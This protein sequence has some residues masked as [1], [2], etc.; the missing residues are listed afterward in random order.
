[1]PSRPAKTTVASESVHGVTAPV[2]RRTAALLGLAL[3]AVIAVRFAEPLQDGDLFS[4]MAYARQMLARGTL[5]LDHAAFSWTPAV[6]DMIYCAWASEL[7]FY[8]LWEHLG[9]TSLFAFRY[10]VVLLVAGLAFIH[11][12]RLG[13]GRSLLTHLIVLILIL[14][15]YTGTFVKP[16]LFSLLGINVLAHVVF[17]AKHRRD[18]PAGAARL[19][20]LVPLVVLV[21]V[22]CHGGFILA[23]PFLLMVAIGEGLNRLWSPGL[24]FSRRTY[25]HLLA[26]WALAGV[27]IVVTPYG[28]AYPRNSLATTSWGSGRAPTWRGTRRIVRSSRPSAVDSS[29]RSFS[30]SWRRCWARS[31][32]CGCVTRRAARAS[33]G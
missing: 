6:S 30:S 14:A 29:S 9:I 32:C 22:N 33:I 11:A 16:E 5:V 3:L 2:T 13:L 28:V 18:Q 8:A 12:R 31:S 20:Y 21:W 15:S 23:A 26:S 1:M 4:H 25:A 19:L 27:A 24:A 10:L 7:F 17:W